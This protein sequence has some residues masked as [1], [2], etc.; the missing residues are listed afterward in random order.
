MQSEEGEERTH[1]SHESNGP[2]VITVSTQK[3]LTAFCT[4]RM[5]RTHTQE[6]KY[7]QAHTDTHT[8]TQIHTSTDIDIHTFQKT[9]TESLEMKTITSNMYIKNYTGDYRRK[10]Q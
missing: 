4:L 8:G 1:E 10:H 2:Q 3:A 9:Q 5:P 7:I 6:R